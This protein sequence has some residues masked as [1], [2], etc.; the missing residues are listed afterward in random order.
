MIS[1]YQAILALHALVLSRKKQLELIKRVYEAETSHFKIY[2]KQNSNKLGKGFM[3]FI[4][5][6]ICL[7][8]CLGE[9]NPH[10]ILLCTWFIMNYRVKSSK[11]IWLAKVRSKTHSWARSGVG[12]KK[13]SLPTYFNGIWDHG[14]YIIIITQ[15]SVSFANGNQGTCR[16]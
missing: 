10:S 4:T 2:T 7:A 1:K 11:S 9:E 15:G 12:Q 13:L 14:P 6:N 3:V 5:G 8:C 16:K